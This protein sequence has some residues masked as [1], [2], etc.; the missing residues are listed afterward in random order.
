[1]AP[2]HDRH[3]AQLSGIVG[4]DRGRLPQR[5]QGTG[6]P[7]RPRSSTGGGR[8]ANPSASSMPSSNGSTRLTA[9]VSSS[10]SGKISPAEGKE[11]TRLCWKRRPWQRESNQIASGK[12]RRSPY[13]LSARAGRSRMTPLD[14]VLRHRAPGWRSIAT[15]LLAALASGLHRQ[16]KPRPRARSCRSSTSG[17]G[18]VA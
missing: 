2:S 15:V 4:S 12:T 11:A 3:R 13:P 5:C 14:F 9:G 6:R 1:M 18:T 17:G 8:G 16:A 10:P 7:S